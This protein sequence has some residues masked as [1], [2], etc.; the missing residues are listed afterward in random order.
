MKLTQTERKQMV[1]DLLKSVRYR[2]V[3][4]KVRQMAAED[5]D[6]L[7][8]ELNLGIAVAMY[9]VKP[10]V[11]DPRE[12]LLNRG[13]WHVHNKVRGKLNQSVQQECMV[14]G[15]LRPYRREPCYT[16]GHSNFLL[17]PRYLPFLL[18]ENGTFPTDD[19]DKYRPAVDTQDVS[20]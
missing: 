2:Q 10:N 20:Y 18:E 13:W 1:E 8:A 5:A 15:K 6:D 19:R 16:C 7:E 17:H 12:Y 3:R 9:E 14:C 4:G 11:G